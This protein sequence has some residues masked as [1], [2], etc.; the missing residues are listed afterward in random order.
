[1]GIPE[2]VRSNFAG[3]LFGAPCSDADL[4]SASAAL[5]EEI[6]VV[7]RDLYRGFNGFRDPDGRQFLWPLFAPQPGHEALVETNQ[8][9]RK[10][11]SL[12][13][14]LAAQCLFFGDPGCGPEFAWGIHRNLPEKVIEVHPDSDTAFSVAGDSPLEVWVAMKHQFEEMRREAEEFARR[15]RFVRQRFTD[16]DMLMAREPNEAGYYASCPYHGEPYDE[17]RFRVVP[18]GWDHEH[19][20]VC[21][22]KVLLN[23]E[24]WRAEPPQQVGLCLE[25]YARLFERD[26]GTRSGLLSF[27]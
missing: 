10:G 16:Q 4:A 9:F 26:Q 11:T 7:L 15:Q 19:C 1:M 22:A 12:S 20:F 3:S 2:D 25:C 14:E 13:Q 18:G 23:E 6:P 24:W 17:T 21:M 5:G 27:P 8:S